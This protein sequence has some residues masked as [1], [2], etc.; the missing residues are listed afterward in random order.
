MAKKTDNQL[1]TSADRGGG[2]GEDGVDIQSIILEEEEDD[3]DG[4]NVV[5]AID[6]I[7]FKSGCSWRL[8]EKKKCGVKKNRITPHRFE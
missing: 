1:R 6:G 8:L 4:E 2:Q 7:N 5:M 3:G